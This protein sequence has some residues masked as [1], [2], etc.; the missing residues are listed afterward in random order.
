MHLTWARSATKHR[1]A[2]DR[3]RFVIDHCGRRYRIPPP[4]GSVDDRWL[5]L[6]DDAGGVALE[7]MA[8][9]LSATTLLVIHAMPMREKYRQLYQEA[10][11]WRI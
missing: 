1:V 2:R 10:R 11:R 7:V 8:V 6:G 3:S 9:E 5:Y 4:L